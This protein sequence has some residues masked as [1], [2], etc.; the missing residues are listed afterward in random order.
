MYDKTVT[1]FNRYENQVGNVFWYPT[2]LKHVDLI[3]DKVA[4]VARTG[5]DSADTAAL[6]VA[7]SPDNGDVIV[8]GKK[9]L[10]PKAWKAQTNEELLQSLT[11]ANTDFF[12]L[13]NFSKAEAAEDLYLLD[14]AGLTI[15]DSNDEPIIAPKNASDPAIVKDADYSNRV[16]RGFYDY[17]NKKY[18]SIFTISN[19]G[20]PYTVIPHF[21]IGG[22]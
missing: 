11:F 12:V 17:L 21:E 18:D 1:L 14:S 15:I 2:V 3:T 8:Q 6:H 5:L 16:D 13:G 10:P 4:N 9:W 22:K 20:G 19:V 7:Y